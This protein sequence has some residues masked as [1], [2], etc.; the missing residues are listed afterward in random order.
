MRKYQRAFAP[1][2]VGV[3]LLGACGGGSKSSSSAALGTSAPAVTSAP[4]TT[5]APAQATSTS[6]F[7]SQLNDYVKST[8]AEGSSP[9]PAQLKASLARGMQL[10]QQSLSLTPSD[11]KPD[12]QIV[13]DA[14]QKYDADIAAAGYN[15]SAV[16]A[17][18]VNATIGTPQVLA[19]EQK[20]DAYYKSSCGTSVP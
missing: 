1:L 3:V 11:L 9:T 2:V 6:S 4:A 18:E 17:S 8:L 15:R 14:N 19:A 10:G 13:L 16:P 5:A 7:C 12:L 20:V